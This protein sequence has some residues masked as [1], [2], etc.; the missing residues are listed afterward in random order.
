MVILFVIFSLIKLLGKSKN[1]YLLSR[2]NLITKKFIRY[3][4]TPTRL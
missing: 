1:K 3:S 4:E 2:T